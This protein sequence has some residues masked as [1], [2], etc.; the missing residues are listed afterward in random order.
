MKAN[1]FETRQILRALLILTAAFLAACSKPMNALMEGDLASL[2]SSESFSSL[3][4]DSPFKSGKVR[5]EPVSSEAGTLSVLSAGSLEAS[6]LLDL[7]CYD[8]R[9][10]ALLV[11]PAL[12]Q[13]QRQAGMKMQAFR[14]SGLSEAW[15]Q[16]NQ[17][18]IEKDE[19]IRGVT[20]EI[21]GQ[22]LAA[23]NDPMLGQQYYLSYLNVPKAWDVLEKA[24]VP[25]DLKVRV[26][27]IDSGVL[28][29][30]ED[31][32]ANLAAPVNGKIGRNMTGDGSGDGNAVYP[33]GTRVAGFI[34]GVMNN[35]VGIA[36]VSANHA[37][38]YPLVVTND[39]GMASVTAVA[40]AVRLAADQGVDVIN[41]SLGFNVNNAMLE[42]SV[43]Y[44]VSKGVFIAIAAGNNGKEVKVG[45]DFMIP[46]IWSANLP[47]VMSTANIDISTDDLHSSSNY[48]AQ[49]IEIAAPGANTPKRGLLTT[50]VDG[51]GQ[52]AYGV[53]TGTSFSS[54]L[55]AS[56]AALVKVM[57][58]HKGR[59]ISAADVESLIT[60]S[61][62]TLGSLSEKVQGGRSLDIGA[63]L[64]QTNTW[65]GGASAPTEDTPYAL[66][67]D[68]I[69]NVTAAVECLCA[70]INNSS[71]GVMGTSAYAA[72][73]NIC[74]AARHAGVFSGLKDTR[75]KIQ[76]I[77][78]CPTFKA[79][80]RNGVASMARAS[81]GD[82]FIFAG[83]SATCDSDDSQGGQGPQ[84]PVEPKPDTTAIETYVEILYLNFMGRAS[85]NAGRNH[86][87]QAVL[88]GL[89]CRD[90]TRSITGS[91]EFAGRQAQMSHRQFMDTLYGGIMVRK[92]DTAGLAYWEGLLNNGTLSRDAVAESFTTSG[93]HRS[94][95][96]K[97]QIAW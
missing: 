14:V 10:G 29:T 12:V 89:S 7:N 70:P 9:G 2:A 94:V 91:P 8:R 27:V 6:V 15:L 68:T 69:T 23:S 38:I 62:K 54:P 51:A 56:A 73:S 90:L 66:M 50:N 71:I 80:T 49:H 40:N 37:E 61:A 1:Q 59:D 79:S 84:N 60:K 11:T 74:K 42:D 55:L 75:V 24:G 33:H 87:V 17:N 45:G 30:H 67:C 64:T 13:S 39:K 58:K 63:L 83:M 78:I 28:L 26:A 44:A 18:E 47:G 77:G 95:C 92:A 41:M 57:A 32:M 20:R 96:E 25:A 93:E 34:S 21:S 76:P 31:L 85:D 88:N 48:G 22:L 4:A 65:L 72:N 52:S 97:Y 16:A 3:T 86:W 43:R 82:A 35:G 81:A 53:G 46:A 36:G 19:C 5:I